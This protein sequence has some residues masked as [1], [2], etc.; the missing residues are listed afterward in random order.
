MGLAEELYG[1]PITFVFMMLNASGNNAADVGAG[2]IQLIHPL[3]SDCEEG[4]EK[5]NHPRA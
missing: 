5:D 3:R 1:E 4:L 2:L